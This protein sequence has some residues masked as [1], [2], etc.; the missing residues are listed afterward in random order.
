[1]WL[2]ENIMLIKYVQKWVDQKLFKNLIKK[3][4]F[5][6]YQRNKVQKMGSSKNEEVDKT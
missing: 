4:F 3:G 2:K 5:I 1:M 6:I